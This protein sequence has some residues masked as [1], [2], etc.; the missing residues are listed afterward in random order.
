[1]S[2]TEVGQV[3]EVLQLQLHFKQEV[4]QARYLWI[5]ADHQLEKV[6]IQD[7]QQQ[8]VL[9]FFAEQRGQFHYPSFTHLFG[10]SF[11]LGTCVD[12]FEFDQRTAW[13]APKAAMYSAENKQHQHSFQP[14]LDEFRELCD[15]QLGRFLASRVVEASGT[16]S[17]LICESF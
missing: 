2:T 14:D 1:M 4:A 7:T 6:L 16:R 3:G 17:R 11:W 10:L 8:Y 5:K 12:L 9:T 15:F 13:V